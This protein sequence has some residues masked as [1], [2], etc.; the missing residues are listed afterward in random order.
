MWASPAMP[1]SAHDLSA[2]RVHGII[3][4]LASVDVMTA[5]DKGY[6]R[7]PGSVCTPFKRRRFRPTA[8]P[9]S[10]RPSSSCTMSKRPGH[11]PA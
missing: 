10:C 1:G 2:A 5:A 6:Q 8:S 7:T 4:A 11:G 3:D 9:R